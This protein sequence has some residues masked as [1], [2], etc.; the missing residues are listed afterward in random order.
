MKK[1]FFE[2]LGLKIAA[3]LLSAVL[4]IFV[5]S[6]GQSEISLDAPL[7]FRNMPAGLE[8]VNHGIKTI[9]LNIKGQERLIKNVK[10]ADIRVYVDLSKARKGEGVYYIDRKEIKLPHTFT[11]TN[12]NPSSIKVTIEETI[13]KTV[14][15]LPMVIGEPKK[16][17]FVKS[18]DVSPQYVV[19]E[20]VRSEII[21]IGNVKTEPIDISGFNESFSQDLKID[22]TGRNVRSKINDV[23]VKVVIGPRGK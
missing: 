23:I 17:Y 2:N 7:E 5:T 13:S 12:I 8:I 3:V 14:K 11:V 6:R 22:L 21:K 18:V 19:I 10:A 9:D 4:W 16:G 1:L 20:G 15:V